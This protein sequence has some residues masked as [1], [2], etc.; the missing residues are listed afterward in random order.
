MSFYNMM[1][2]KNS[3][4]AIAA[5]IVLGYNVQE[6]FPRFRDIF[7]G[8]THMPK[9][10]RGVGHDVIIYTRMGGD[11]RECWDQ[12]NK[13]N[14]DPQTCACPACSASKLEKEVCV[15]RY[16]DD[17]DCTFSCFLIKFTPEQK[18]LFD[19]IIKS[20]NVDEL[21]MI[22]EFME[23]IKILFPKMYDKYLEDNKGELL[24]AENK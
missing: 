11:N 3:D 22:P 7:T 21:K 24:Y 1:F 13:K 2:G 18:A 12:W 15:G 10:F 19:K 8:D 4:L 20:K 23:G 17:F 9:E 16:D 14:Y 5:S 6:K